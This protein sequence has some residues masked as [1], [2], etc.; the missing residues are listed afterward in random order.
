MRTR[1]T[2]FCTPRG[3]QRWGEG[4]L[5]RVPASS[6]RPSQRTLPCS[7][8]SVAI[9]GRNQTRGRLSEGAPHE[10]SSQG[11]SQSRGLWLS[12]G[13]HAWQT[14]RPVEQVP[15][16]LWQEQ[17]PLTV[18]SGKPGQGP[19]CPRTHS[20]LPTL[21]HPLPGLASRSEAIWTTFTAVSTQG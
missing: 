11:D 7:V 21:I 2:S 19:P 18:T 9:T 5:E 16:Q 17:M 3:E 4:K 12:Q 20:G 6:L 15:I 10:W 8:G 13:L 14:W 1:H